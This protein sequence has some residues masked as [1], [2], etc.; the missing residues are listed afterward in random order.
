MKAL[1]CFL[2]SVSMFMTSAQKSADPKMTARLNQYMQLSRNLKFEEVMELTHPRLFTVAPKEAIVE[3]MNSVFNNKEM[4]F[5]FDSMSIQTISPVYTFNKVA[6]HKI[7]YHTVMTIAFADSVDLSNK[8]LANL[9]M[10]SFKK[11]FVGKRISINEKENA[12]RVAGTE[13]MFAIKDAPNTE[14]MFLGYDRSKPELN[15]R[16]YPKTVRQYFKLS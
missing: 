12:I 16:I 13:I 6:Y 5:R 14:W 8:D 4:T 3:A 11:G 2:F 9:M 1:L 7:A 15:N 10:Q